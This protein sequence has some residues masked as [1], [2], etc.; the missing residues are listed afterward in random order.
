MRTRLDDFSNP[1]LSSLCSLHG[2]H[3]FRN[4]SVLD[5]RPCH[6]LFPVHESQMVFQQLV[7][8]LSMLR[9]EFFINK[10]NSLV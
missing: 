7:W 8:Q 5:V 9:R 3:G 1:N 2:N 10:N 6:R 4:R